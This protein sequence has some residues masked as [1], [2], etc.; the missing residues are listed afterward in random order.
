MQAYSPQDD[1]SA[2]EVFQGVLAVLHN[3][4]AMDQL[5]LA[6]LPVTGCL[7]FGDCEELPRGT[8]RSIRAGDRSSRNK[9]RS[10]LKATAI[11]QS[12][13]T[14]RG[15][16]TKSAGFLGRSLRSVLRGMVPISATCMVRPTGKIRDLDRAFGHRKVGRN[17][18]CADRV[19][20]TTFHSQSRAA[21][22]PRSAGTAGLQ[23]RPQAARRKS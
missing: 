17:F 7:G 4:W 14:R 10:T 2:S 12:G 15:W 6:E 1:A 23:H 11:R 22:G 19:P 9:A 16:S 8:Q 5:D 20:E 18:A 13:Q 21:C 3:V